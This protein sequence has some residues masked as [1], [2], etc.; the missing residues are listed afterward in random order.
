MK[1]MM[2]MVLLVVACGDVDRT[3]SGWGITETVQ[4]P[5]DIEAQE[6]ED[7]EPE[8][9]EPEDVEPQE[10]EDVEPQEPEDVE[11]QEPEDNHP[12]PSYPHYP[13]EGGVVCEERTLVTPG[14]QWF[15]YDL[16]KT[17]VGTE[18]TRVCPLEMVEAPVFFELQ[19]ES[20][21]ALQINVRSEDPDLYVSTSIQV[22]D[23]QI[24]R[25]YP[26]C[27]DPL[28]LEARGFDACLGYTDGIGRGNTVSLVVSRP[29]DLDGFS[30]NT[31][32]LLVLSHYGV[33]DGLC[34][35]TRSC[36]MIMDVV[37]HF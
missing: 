32:T 33:F 3:S 9:V 24:A 10:P 17:Q 11:A 7:V 22:V 26:S 12:A 35:G 13:G 19:W 31:T 36:R 18:Y 28:T 5:E 21:P 15:V 14:D 23:D 30:T 34:D 16:T 1:R 2:M 29:E 8:D 20:Y 25:H 6:P 37:P 4:E 27:S